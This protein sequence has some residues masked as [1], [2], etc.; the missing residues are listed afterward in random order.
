[1]V[2]ELANDIGQLIGQLGVTPGEPDKDRIQSRSRAQHPRGFG[3][4]LR[5]LD[6][7][8]VV[9]QRLESIHQATE[10][11][12]GIRLLIALRR[13]QI[14]AH[15]QTQK[16]L[17]QRL[18]LGAQCEISGLHPPP[19]GLDQCGNTR[20]SRREALVGA[21]I[22]SERRRDFL[23]LLLRRGQ[24][25]TNHGGPAFMERPL[26]LEIGLPSL[27]SRQ[28]GLRLTQAQL[29]LSARRPKIDIERLRV[30]RRTGRRHALANAPRLLGSRSRAIF[31]RSGAL[32]V[33]IRLLEIA[34]GLAVARKDLRLD[35]RVQIGARLGLRNPGLQ[36]LS[37]NQ[38]WIRG[39]DVGARRAKRRPHGT[40]P[41]A[42]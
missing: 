34:Q 4:G 39:S 3:L 5:R 6:L 37:G 40:Q 22:D 12:N 23:L 29:D 14:Q 42:Q 41:K 24:A 26:P 30:I 17:L 21:G 18:D 1:V 16:L 20:G 10:P 25:L 2:V 13:K 28:I 19:S 31:E 7:V 33:H 27:C 11:A 8:F 38:R 9:E 32:P 15:R 35:V 36:T